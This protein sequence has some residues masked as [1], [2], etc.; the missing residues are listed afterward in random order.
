MINKAKLNAE[1]HGLVAKY[2]VADFRHLS[3]T[4]REKFDAI[5][6]LGNSLP[7]LLTDSDLAMALTEMEKSLNDDGLLIIH[8]RN[9]DRLS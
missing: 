3:E 6:C 9:Y 4:L 8:Q 7:H 5:V 1:R 2:E